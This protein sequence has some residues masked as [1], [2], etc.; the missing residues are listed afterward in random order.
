MSK[1]HIQKIFDTY[2]NRVTIEKYSSVV[3]IDEIA[4][5][6][7]N[8]NIP[9]Y[10]DTFEDESPIDIAETAGKLKNLD[11]ELKN[12]NADIVKYCKELDID[13]PF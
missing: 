8:L 2:K 12:I 5:N 1:E 11:M 7:Y 13:T 4:E 9:R 6:D 3:S 10:V